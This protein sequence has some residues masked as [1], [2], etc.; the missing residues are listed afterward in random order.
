MNKIQKILLI[1]MIIVIAA[2]GIYVL[3]FFSSYKKE[4]LVEEEKIKYGYTLYKRDNDLYKEIFNKLKNTLSTDE[5]DYEVYGEYITELF[6]IDF[7]SLNNKDSKDDI[8]GL[9]YLYE[10]TK[11][12]FKLKASN[13][14]Y[15]YIGSTKISDLPEVISIELTNIESTTYTVDTINYEAYK[16]ELKWEYKKDLEYDKSGSFILIKDDDQLYIVEK[17]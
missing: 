17:S 2:I 7:Y 11:G 6:V 1:L 5:I 3:V 16:V 8:G 14:M 12:N 13:T 9:Q 4:T 15:K 10:A